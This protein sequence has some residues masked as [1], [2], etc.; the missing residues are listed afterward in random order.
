MRVPITL[1]IFNRDGVNDDV[2]W[3]VGVAK[4]EGF[5]IV[6]A[7][8]RDSGHGEAAAFRNA[9]MI[10]FPASIFVLSL[11][12]WIYVTK[13]ISPLNQ[14]GGAMEK[15]S[16]TGLRNQ[17]E[18]DGEYE[19]FELLI[20][21]F[22][23]LRERLD[24]SFEQATRFSADA[25]HELKTPL[26]VIQGQIE[27]ALQS[28]QAGSKEQ[29]ALAS[30]LDEVFRLKSIT[31]KLLI[32]AQADAGKLEV[33]L[34]TVELGKLVD[35]T[36]S[37]ILDTDS[38]LK[39]QVNSDVSVKVECDVSLTRQILINLFSNAHKYRWPLDSEVAVNLTECEGLGVLEIL[40]GCQAINEE[41]RAAVFDR[42]ARMDLSRNRETEGVGLGLSI[43]REFAKAQGGTLE[44]MATGRSDQ[45][46]FR[47]SLPVG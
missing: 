19:E 34:E 35:D 7:I 22:N 12:I 40:N 32:L 3:R 43:A 14:L 33:K 30:I 26:T 25:A 8:S 10:V 39:I 5:N 11:C 4:H 21:R 29:I 31:R 28:A 13:A 17:V 18:V 41:R 27:A 6:L 37:T 46:G 44:L 9:L 24:K 1:S 23:A 15:L 20:A 47:L 42:F 38:E 2:S 45:I 16:V 36:V